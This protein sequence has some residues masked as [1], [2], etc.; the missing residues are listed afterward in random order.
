[1]ASKRELEDMWLYFESVGCITIDPHSKRIKDLKKNLRSVGLYH[2]RIHVFEKVAPS[3]L[4]AEPEQ[5]TLAQIC[6]YGKSTVGPVGSELAKSH[7]KIIREA[8]ESG[9]ATVVVLEDDAQFDVERT[10]NVLPNVVP[11]LMGHSWDILNFGAIEFP[12]PVRIPIAK[13]IAMALKPLLGHA[14]AL[15]RA[16]MKKA[17]DMWDSKQPTLHIDKMFASLF[18]QYHVVQPP[19]SFQTEKPALFRQAMEKLPRC[20][21]EVVNRGTFEHFCKRYHQKLIQANVFVL[22]FV[23]ATIFAAGVSKTRR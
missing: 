9:M 3:N 5:T 2:A 15:S 13:G 16:G 22:L 4:A 1:M 21:S 6:A 19:I 7:V 10:A 17:L 23:T 14:Y 12:I 20:V 18:K 8:Y 11:W